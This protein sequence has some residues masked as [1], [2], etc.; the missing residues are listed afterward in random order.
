MSICFSPL[1]FS[2]LYLLAST[3][4]DVRDVNTTR[5]NLCYNG[6]VWWLFV[7]AIRKAKRDR[8]ESK[9]PIE[10]TLNDDGTRVLGRQPSGEPKQPRILDESKENPV[11]SKREQ[12]G[13]VEV[14]GEE[15]KP[16]DKDPER[17]P[18]E[19]K[20]G[21]KPMD[22]AELDEKR[23]VLD[24][25]MQKELQEGFAYYQWFQNFMEEAQEQIQ[26]RNDPKQKDGAPI[27]EAAKGKAT[28]SQDRE[29]AAKALEQ[30][31]KKLVDLKLTVCASVI[32][33]M[34]MI[35]KLRTS[36]LWSLRL[37]I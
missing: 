31:E 21:G 34:L 4:L 26:R 9:F 18:P 37:A 5:S 23:P 29:A 17:K 30:I 3:P 1:L 7:T 6:K 14:V 27:P 12:T 35:T 24:V 25:P 22:G 11:V 16:P 8:P 10:I 28:A 2:Y 19:D 13:I 36:N 33:Q 20:S 32:N 15:V